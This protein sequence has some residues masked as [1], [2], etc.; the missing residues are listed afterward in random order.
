MKHISPQ[1]YSE[2]MLSRIQIMNISYFFDKPLGF[3]SH[4]WIVSFQ[5]N[6]LNSLNIF[7]LSKWLGAG[8]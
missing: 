2:I 3:F 7:A 6:I 8:R 1:Y 5:N 4:F